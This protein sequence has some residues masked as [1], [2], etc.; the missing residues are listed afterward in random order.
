MTYAQNNRLGRQ[1]AANV[2]ADCRA[3]DNL[4]K[5]AREIRA[6]TLDESGIGAG[7]LFTLAEMITAG[8]K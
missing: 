6:A 8:S 5:L 2:I 4:P 1:H 7:F 3:T